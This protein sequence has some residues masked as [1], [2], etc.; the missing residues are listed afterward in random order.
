MLITR[1]IQAQIESKLFQD[2]LVVVYGPRQ[3][4]KTTLV[5]QIQKNYQCLYLN[6]DEPDVRSALTNKTSTELKAYIGPQQL[7]VIDEAQRVHNI[8]LTLKLLVD[9]YP[10]IQ[11]IAT[12]SSSF[13]LS[14]QISEPLTGRMYEFHLYPL[15]LVEL[16]SKYNRVELNRLKENFL[17]FGTYPDIISQTSGVSSLLSNLTKSYLYKDALEYQ[18]I[19]NPELVEKLVQALA[20]QI[21]SEVSYTELATLLGIDKKTVERYIRLLEQAFVI[22]RLPPLSRNMRNELSKKRKIY[23]WDTGI[24]NALINN[25][26]SISLR[27]DKGALW[28]NFLIA[29]RLIKLNNQLT[30][31]Q[32]FFWRTWQQMEIDYIEEIQGKMTAYEI[33]WGGKSSRPPKDWSKGY[34]QAGYNII[35]Q[36]NWLDF[37]LP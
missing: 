36:N 14:N 18:T 29:Q 9:N 1:S 8:G 33:T 25:L 23:F 4:G 34:P 24:R 15:S 5:T 7:V 12:G 27:T 3:V 37:L 31:P 26:N 17:I 21:G 19:K 10:Q 30:F 35:N 20:L 6:C 2:K 22:F 16:S 13:E 32:T 11:I 28:E